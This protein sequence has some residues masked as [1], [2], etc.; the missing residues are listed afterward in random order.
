[1]GATYLMAN[2]YNGRYFTEK[3]IQKHAL[4]HMDI[5]VGY[6]AKYIFN[7]MNINAQQI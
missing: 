6:H 2:Y 5:A 7:L 4:Y 3:Q 1:M